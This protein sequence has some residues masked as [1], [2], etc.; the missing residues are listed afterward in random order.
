MKKNFPVTSVENDYNDEMEIISTTNTTGVITGVN[1]DFIKIA[2]FSEEEFLGKSHNVV[3]HPDMPQAAFADMWGHL[4]DG[5]HWMGVVK[6]RC[7]NGDHYWVD[8]YVTPIEE[9]GEITSYESVRVKPAKSLVERAEY[10]YQRINAGKAAKLPGLNLGLKQQIFYGAS[11]ISVLALLVPVL[12]GFRNFL[13]L[14]V[15]LP[16]FIFC[17]YLL[18]NWVTKPL[19]EAANKT[20]DIVDNPLMS[21]IYTGRTDEIGQLQLSNKILKARLGTVLGRVRHSGS[22]ISDIADETANSLDNTCG[23]MEHQCSET[24]SLSAAV[25]KLSS[26]IQKIEEHASQAAQIATDAYQESEGG[27]TSATET[28]QAIKSFSEAVQVVGGLQQDAKN[29]EG[30]LGVIRDIADQTNLLALNASIEAARAGEHGR[31]FAVVADEVRG[32]AERTQ[33]STTEIKNVVESLHKG[34]DNTIKIIRYSSERAENSMGQIQN[35][36][37]SFD[38]I[39]TK[40]R[41]ISSMSDQIASSVKEQSIVVGGINHSVVSIRQKAEGVAEETRNVS[42]SAH[43]LANLVRDLEGLT[44]RFRA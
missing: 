12:S 9:N 10:L 42:G 1:D 14:A 5:K 33:H 27:A 22:I 44:Q 37:D 13:P 28:I 34:V 29:I 7:K 4:K 43:S 40:I 21:L 3:R 16:V 30:M 2:G 26:S 6:N 35:T 24:E 8:A 31:G 11:I 19:T 18:A 38:C 15:V 25:N 36:V 20:K 23:S 39:T 41:D 17:S 32:L